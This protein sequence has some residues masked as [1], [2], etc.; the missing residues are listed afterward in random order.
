MSATGLHEHAVFCIGVSHHGAP[1]ELL[2]RL[3]I[4]F[5]MLPQAL[6]P[7]AARGPD[8]RRICEG[9]VL[10]TC[11]RTEIYASHGG[12]DRPAAGVVCFAG[13][14]D[15]VVDF[16][17]HRSGLN[18]DEL[19]RRL[20]RHDGGA[21][22]EHLFRVVCG[23][24]SLVAGESQIGGQVARAY[25]AAQAAGTAGVVLSTLFQEAIRGGRRARAR[26]GIGRGAANV[27]SLAVSRAEVLVGPLAQAHAVVIGTGE[28]GRIV[29]RS[30]R[31]H[32]ARRV[33]IVSRSE[34]RAAEAA[35]RWGCGAHPRS[36]LP[37]LLESCDV[38]ISTTSAAGP[39]FGAGLIGGVMKE[40]GG[41]RLVL[42]DLAVPRTVDAAARGVENVTLLD[43]DSFKDDCESRLTPEMAR[44]ETMIGEDLVVLRLRM[45][46]LALRPVIGGLWRRAAAIRA[47]V[48]ARMRAR[49]PDLDAET[50]TQVEDLATSLVARL[51][52]DPA[53]R[54][55]A[56]AG[57]GH[58]A[59]YAEA[60]RELFGVTESQPRRPRGPRVRLGTRSSRLA[61]W[62][63]QK[64]AAL[65]RG[66]GVE[67][68]IVPIET[69][70]DDISD[71]PLPE[72]GGDGV[73][74]E[75]IET[76]L[77]ASEID[78]A[79]HSLKDLP[80][81]DPD[82]LCVGAILGREEVRDVLISRAGASLAALPPGAVVGSS[83]TR[84]QAQ[85]LSIRP[86]LV[87]R[88][89]RGNVETRI[90]KVESGEYDATLL[91]GAGVLRLGLEGK[92]AEWL[93]I[94][95]VLPAPG[96]GAIAV[97]SPDR[98]QRDAGGPGGNR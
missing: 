45:K 85:V 61:L 53:T 23:L 19:A 28:I 16:L 72:I 92:I 97:Q 13:I 1:L 6:S 74:T 8:G 96:Q 56:E 87:L 4:P 78:I 62:Q 14:P 59:A 60:L 68:D 70:G 30:L 36:A 64:V 79:V 84:R 42:I 38:C 67:C 26:I 35:R 75:R 7:F 89:I 65:L 49:L 71:R 81:Q 9:V 51:L 12:F 11:N 48:L 40:R 93:E 54:L 82:E 25:S 80:V 5:D 63:A 3:S 31:E 98:G 29:L 46:E 77:R 95:A 50:W 69:R 86:D 21:A 76:S 20:Y 17:C 22:V 52:H 24:D 33:D 43:I 27:G 37:V 58:A 57:N 44:V 18:R 47:D 73:F 91:A 39:L 34:T 88:P 83:S 94:A 90:R 32:G 2:E 15:G 10:S 66:R 55:R 41:R